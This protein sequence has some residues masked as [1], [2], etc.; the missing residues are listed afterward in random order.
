MSSR[1]LRMGA[2]SAAIST[3]ACAMGGQLPYQSP[4]QHLGVASCAS[5]LCHGA[6]E[7]NVQATVR[8]D[9][10]V[11]WSHRDA[12]ARAYDVL[13]GE[14]SRS[15]AAK[16]ALPS[17]QGAKICLDCHTDNVPQA[18]RGARFTLSDGVGCEACH[19]GAEHWIASHV[20]PKATY[21][22][23]VA[24]GLYPLA[25]LP[26]RARLC[27]ACH[28]GN[29]DKFATH[30]IMAAGHPRLAFELDTYLALEP[31]HYTV[32]DKY[33]LRKPGYNHTQTWVA[34][35]LA[36]SALQLG[37]LQSDR[38]RTAG[39]FPELAL[40]NCSAC[41]DSSTERSEWRRRA[42]TQQ[43]APGTVPLNDAYWRMSWLITRALDAAEGARF[44][45]LGE[46]LQR[47]VLVSRE[48]IAVRARELSGV[49]DQGQARSTAQ[50]WSTAKS[51][52]I[53][54]SLLQ[55]GAEGEFRD[56]LGAE[57]AV[58]AAELLLIDEGRAA[59][60]RPQLDSLYR[61]VKNID[62]FRAADF[63]AA[64]KTLEAALA[65]DGAS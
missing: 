3:W 45:A 32:D 54:K 57:Q 14:R 19:G 55:A 41:H 13:A 63:A 49:L 40:F 7:P 12:H 21:R 8:L 51:A 39:V 59:R 34:G 27:D 20:T 9:E 61:Q 15:I 65:A 52:Q 44:L 64:V 33:R 29:S 5:S 37:Q 47:S 28:V 42:M 11:T 56:Y 17:A 2:V 31:P 18:Q 10:F 50:I 46:D 43:I 38:L 36:A 58:M 4:D 48:Q 25:D 35:Q 24:H 1:R 62:A 16:L 23:D 30:T 53:L 6:V 22:D 60:M 26:D